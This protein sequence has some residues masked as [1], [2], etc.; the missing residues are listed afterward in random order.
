MKNY[1]LR[2]DNVLKCWIVWKR[3]GTSGWVIAYK[4]TKKKDAKK[5]LKGKTKK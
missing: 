2:K 4:T 3:V 1:K 5:W